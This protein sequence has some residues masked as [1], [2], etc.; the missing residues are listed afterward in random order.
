MFLLK[1]N[2][3]AFI[4]K[5]PRYAH[6]LAADP[7][8]GA[9]L[10]QAL[11]GPA[12]PTTG[13]WATLISQYPQAC[14]PERSGCRL[15]THLRSPLQHP[16]VLINASPFSIGRN[17]KCNLNLKEPNLSSIIC[18]LTLANA[19]PYIDGSSSSASLVLNG[20]PLKKGGRMPLRSGDEI[21]ISGLKPYSYVR[22]A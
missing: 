6:Q 8:A 5:F 21:S 11:Q 10:A 12:A 1:N 16:N 17:S 4:N 15:T 18:R 3:S 7:A 13:N 20:R 2:L 19:L 14:A 22:P 9:E